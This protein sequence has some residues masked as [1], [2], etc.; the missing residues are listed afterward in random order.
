MGPIGCTETSVSN[1]QRTLFKTK[2]IED[3][4][5]TAAEA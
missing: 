5:Q 3:F 1:Y 4:S 2:K